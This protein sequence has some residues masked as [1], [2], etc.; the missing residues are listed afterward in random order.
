VLASTWPVL[1][2]DNLDFTAGGCLTAAGIGGAG[3]LDLLG[4]YFY[5]TIDFTAASQKPRYPIIVLMAGI[6][7]II[8]K[9]CLKF[10]MPQCETLG[11]G[12][13]QGRAHALVLDPSS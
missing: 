11:M 7:D 13:T 3:L 6:N 10:T 4:Q 5:F 9:V 12:C 1:L 2:A 8:R